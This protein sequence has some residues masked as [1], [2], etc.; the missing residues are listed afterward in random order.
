MK[1][2]LLSGGSGKR[3][4]PLSNDSR[5]KQFLKLLESPSG[6]KESMTQRVV[7]QIAESGIEADVT[8]ATSASQKDI[9]ISQF[10]DS[11]RIV[12]EPMRRDTFPAIALSCAYLHSEQGCRDDEV[13]AVLPSDQ[14]TEAGYFETIRKMGV[15]AGHDNFDI[16]LMGI[17]PES[18]SPNFGYILPGNTENGIRRVKSFVEKP[19]VDK[20]EEI[21][22]EGGL[23]NGGVFAFRL[24]YV[25]KKVESILGTSEYSDVLSRYQ[26]LPKISFDYEVVEKAESIGVIPFKGEW[27][28]LGSWDALVAHIRHDSDN[29]IISKCTGT[30]VVNELDIPIICLGAD[31]ITVAASHDG[32]LVT[33]K[34]MAPALKEILAS[35]DS[36]PKFEERR[37][38]EFRIIDS[39]TEPEGYHSITKRLT[40]KAGKSISYQRHNHRSEVWTIVKGKGMMV[41][42]GKTFD[43]TPG[44]TVQIAERQLHSIKAL[45]DIEIIEVQ[46]GTILREDDIERFDWEW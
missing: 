23:W 30:K 27:K 1:I 13:V 19:S 36:R 40:I 45:A 2:I 21:I 6:N 4:W 35:V 10:G 37:W 11:V 46:F 24:G 42:D 29:C 25:I 34:D 32:I 7:R 26:E 18:P 28:D 22:S 41:L 33:G 9:I 31:N 39:T 8:I 20:A 12:T 44:T 16:V 43:V 17:E 5:S 15:A 14:F 3:L 38:G